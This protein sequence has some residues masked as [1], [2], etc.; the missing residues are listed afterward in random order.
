MASA[1]GSSSAA[2]TG[3]QSSIPDPSPGARW[4]RT[5]AASA[6]RSGTCCGAGIPDAR[7]KKP[8]SS[9]VPTATT[10]TPRDSRTSS[11]PATSRIAFGP[12]H[13][14]TTGVRASSSR[15]TETSRLGGRRVPSGARTASNAPG[16]TPADPTGRE[17]ADAGCGTGE[18]GRRDGG[19]AE[20]SGGE[21]PG[22]RRP[23][24]LPDVGGRGQ[25]HEGR[26][27]KPYEQP[28]IP[29]RDRRRHGAGLADGRLRGA[30]D[31]QVS[32]IRE[33]VADERGFEG[34]DRASSPERG[35]DLRGNQESIA[36]TADN[37]FVH[38]QRVP[39][40]VKRPPIAQGP[41]EP[42][43]P[44]VGLRQLGT[45]TGMIAGTA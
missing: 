30:G 9:S 37:G 19:R 40:P 3:T 27:V 2:G 36:E 31:L 11:V 1:R 20:H 26:R 5:R 8:G 42:A 10:G 22:Q 28:T 7:E 12:A 44:P 43:D 45:I 15:S 25:L 4:I 41:L 16:W 32:G 34:H 33:A 6:A 21:R 13:T 35:A 29:D 24:N 23:G 18:H 17:D 38:L 14:T 39:L